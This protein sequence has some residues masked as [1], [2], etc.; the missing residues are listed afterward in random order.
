MFT[1]MTEVNIGV[2]RITKLIDKC[3]VIYSDEIDI[4]IF[5][6]EHP[7]RFKS[8]IEI[9]EAEPFE[10]TDIAS[11]PDNGC[12][13]VSDSGK[14]LIWSSDVNKTVNN[15]KTFADVDGIP[16]SLSVTARGRLLVTNELH[17]SLDMFD[18]NGFLGRIETYF[19][20]EKDYVPHG[21]ETINGTFIVCNGFVHYHPPSRVRIIGQRRENC[22]VILVVLAVAVVQRTKPAIVIVSVS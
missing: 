1:T 11:D 10:L 9:A 3:Y 13:Y 17:S 19:G 12:L 6:S 20:P 8:S 21:V 2:T 7:Y 22:S 18:N 16:G 4:D 15:V 5:E 14:Q